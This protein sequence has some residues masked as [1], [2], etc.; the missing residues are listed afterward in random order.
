VAIIAM[1]APV[2]MSAK[3]DLIVVSFVLTDCIGARDG[4]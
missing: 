4:T 2:A 1:T 3:R